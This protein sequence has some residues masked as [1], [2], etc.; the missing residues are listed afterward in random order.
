MGSPVDDALDRLEKA[1]LELWPPLKR[2]WAA[3]IATVRQRLAEQDTEIQRLREER[4]AALA[5]DER[6]RRAWD[7]EVN[8]RIAAEA[9]VR[10]LTES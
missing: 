9:E 1:G 8:R 10:R 6:T 5:W 7:E 2:E 3:T 4:D